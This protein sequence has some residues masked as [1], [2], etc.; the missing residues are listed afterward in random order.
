VLA[1]AR[2]S[3]ASAVRVLRPPVIAGH[4]GDGH[5]N[6]RTP[7][8]YALFVRHFCRCFHDLRVTSG[9]Y[10]GVRRRRRVVVSYARFA[11]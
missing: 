2:R 8:R 10:R 9:E 3:R 11:G 1:A 6:G 7:D 5:P 4:A